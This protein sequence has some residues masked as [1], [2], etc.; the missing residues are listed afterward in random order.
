MV[1]V[2]HGGELAGHWHGAVGRGQH[3][4]ALSRPTGWAEQGCA[5][6]AGRCCLTEGGPKNRGVFLAHPMQGL[7]SSGSS[8]PI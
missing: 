6:G 1:S 5:G 2:C 4:V 7:G 8:L 3:L